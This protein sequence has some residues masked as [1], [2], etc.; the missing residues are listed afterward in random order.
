MVMAQHVCGK[1][2][3]RQHEGGAVPIRRGEEGKGVRRQRSNGDET[4]V[5]FMLGYCPMPGYNSKV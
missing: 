3:A 2:M 4:C 5:E 1:S